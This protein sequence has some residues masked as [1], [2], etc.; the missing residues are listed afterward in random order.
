MSSD[1]RQKSRGCAPIREVLR[2]T[3]MRNV[4]RQS[5][6]PAI[7]NYGQNPAIRQLPFKRYS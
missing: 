4:I 1:G 6:N 3:E 7:G 2:M 5:G